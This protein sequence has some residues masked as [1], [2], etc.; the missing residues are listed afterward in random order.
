M[1]PLRPDGVRR[2]RHGLHG[3]LADALLSR[4]LDRLLIIAVGV[5]VSFVLFA[6]ER[7]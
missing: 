4:R 5:L 6:A 7:Y 1:V 2:H 3:S